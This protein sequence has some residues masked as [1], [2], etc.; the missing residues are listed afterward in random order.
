MTKTRNTPICA[1]CDK[2]IVIPGDNVMFIQVGV[3]TNDRANHFVTFVE[4]DS[5][6]IHT[7]CFSPMM[8]DGVF[9]H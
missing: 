4:T 2:P 6:L 7:K 5:K 8:L 1:H 9:N 3:T